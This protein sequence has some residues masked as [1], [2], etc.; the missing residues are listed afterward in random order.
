MNSKLHNIQK[1]ARRAEAVRQGAYDGRFGH[2]VIADPKKE[3]DRLRCR[4]QVERGLEEVAE[5]TI[6]PSPWRIS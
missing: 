4:E 1:G 3:A 2:R 5:A 6:E